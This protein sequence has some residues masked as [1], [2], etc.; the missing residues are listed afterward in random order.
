MM[1]ITS[2]TMV[3]VMSVL[4]EYATSAHAGAPLPPP[5]PFQA[6]DVLQTP[7]GPTSRPLPQARPIPQPDWNNAQALPYWLQAP[8]RALLYPG[9]RQ[10]THDV[11]PVPSQSGQAQGRGQAQ[12]RGQA[13]GGFG[14]SGSVGVQSRVRTQAAQGWRQPYPS[15][16]NPFPGAGYPRPTYRQ[17]WPQNPWAGFG[18]APSFGQWAPYPRYGYGVAP[19]YRPQPGYNQPAGVSK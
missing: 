18:A 11:S 1:R 14:F 5:G 9:N 6:E 4:A 19:G 10:A 7:S 15:P 17:A 2:L 3:L 12:A 13:R 8:A 16:Y